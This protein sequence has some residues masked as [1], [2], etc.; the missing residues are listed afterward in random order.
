M[1][2]LNQL[3]LKLSKEAIA[4]DIEVQKVKEKKVVGKAQVSNK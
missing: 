2:G 3:V 4:T 1:L